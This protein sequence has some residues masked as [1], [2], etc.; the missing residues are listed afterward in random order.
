MTVQSIVY[1]L[2]LATSSI[3]AFLLYRAYL[4]SRIPLLFWSALS[5]VFLALNNLFVV[6][7]ML[8]FATVDLLWLRQLAAFCAIGVLLY[9]FIWELE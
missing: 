3:C 1:I 2:C 9:A 6:A 7:D 8:V 5:F 4:G